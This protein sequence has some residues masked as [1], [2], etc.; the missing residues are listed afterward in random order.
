MLSRF[1]NPAWRVAR[2]AV[3]AGTLAGLAV[4]GACSD[5]STKSITAPLAP[6]NSTIFGT[7]GGAFAFARVINVCVDGG[8]PSGTYTF[9]TSDIRSNTYFGGTDDANGGSG[10]TTPNVAGTYDLTPGGGCA[11]VITRTAPDQ[12]L[13][14]SST[15][16]TGTEVGC[17][18]GNG[19]GADTW[20]GITVTATGIPATAQYV[21]TNCALDEGTRAAIPDPCGALNNPTRAYVNFSHGS[22]LTFVFGPASVPDVPVLFVIGDLAPWSIAVAGA[23]IKGNKPVPPST[24]NFWGSQWWKN[25]PMSQFHSN[26]WPSF[27]GYASSVD[28]TAVAGAPCGT[29]ISRV[30][31]SPP[32]PQTIP[33]L[34]GV[35]ITNNVVKVGPDLGGGIQEIIVVHSD[36]GYGPNPGHDGNGPVVSIL[37][38]GQQ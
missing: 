20:S 23:P 11:T 10:T 16:P 31:N 18:G 19:V 17:T 37:C 5:T 34:V 1:S 3:A 33:D 2:V 13:L 29:W 36:G 38:G 15:C 7:G 35:I 6:R 22:Q 32:P 8:S 24:V 12:G 27:K 14:G 30:G 25:N 26:G 28:R 9:T 4:L 21:S